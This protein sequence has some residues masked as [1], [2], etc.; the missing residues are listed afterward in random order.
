MARIKIWGGPNHGEEYNVAEQARRTYDGVG[1]PA[2][3]ILLNAPIPFPAPGPFALNRDEQLVPRY[4]IITYRRREYSPTMKMWL[5]TPDDYQ[6]GHN[7][8]S[9]SV[10][11]SVSEFRDSTPETD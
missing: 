10:S 1:V 4:E 3:T 7:D 8:V 5:Y 9:E 11:E 2:D 6:W